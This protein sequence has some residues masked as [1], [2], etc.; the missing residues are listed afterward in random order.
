MA[1][2]V[3]DGVLLAHRG[4]ALHHHLA[5]AEAQLLRVALGVGRLASAVESFAS[6]LPHP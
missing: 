1:G 2:V 6:A 5:V 3:V 4:T